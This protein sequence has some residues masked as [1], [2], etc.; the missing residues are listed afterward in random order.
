M[1]PEVNICRFRQILQ[2]FYEIYLELVEESTSVERTM[3]E[4]I[5]STNANRE[6]LTHQPTN[7]EYTLLLDIYRNFN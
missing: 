7:V 6:I 4:S 5:F 2:W 1:Q 3:E